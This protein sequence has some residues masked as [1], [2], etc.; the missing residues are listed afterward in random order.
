MTGR[1]SMRACSRRRLW[2]LGN[3]HKGLRSGRR[4][5]WWPSARKRRH[6]LGIV[7]VRNCLRVAASV[8]RLGD[9]KLS[10]AFWGVKGI[11]DGG[12]CDEGKCKDL[13]R[14][15]SCERTVPQP[16]SQQN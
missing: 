16:V 13:I 6:F 9:L 4:R 8:G 14:R 3:G 11:C 7:V 5:F 15:G 12:Y 2:G 10:P 1:Q